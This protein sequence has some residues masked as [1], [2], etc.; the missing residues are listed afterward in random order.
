MLRTGK[1][2]EELVQALQTLLIISVRVV[3]A[4]AL[5]ERFLENLPMQWPITRIDAIGI[6]GDGGASQ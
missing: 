4:S 3:L 5:L 1:T 2:L 6:G